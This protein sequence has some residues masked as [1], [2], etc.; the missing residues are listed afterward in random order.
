MTE[1]NSGVILSDANQQ[2]GPT[3]ESLK[4]SVS[5]SEAVGS[6]LHLAVC[7]MPDLSHSVGITSRFVGDPK[8]CHWHALRSILRRLR[9]NVKLGIMFREYGG[10]WIGYSGSDYR[11][12]L[13]K[14]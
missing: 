2:L 1:S 12:E 14:R 7:T 9:S 10:N 8:V 13:V 5:Y 3:G 6:L 4:G 11:G